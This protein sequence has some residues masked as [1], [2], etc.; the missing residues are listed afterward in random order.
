MQH[1]LGPLVM[2]R[3]VAETVTRKLILFIFIYRMNSCHTGRSMFWNDRVW[4]VL[5]DCGPQGSHRGAQPG[6]CSPVTAEKFRVMGLPCAQQDSQQQPCPLSMTASSSFFQQCQSQM[7]QT[8]PDVPWEA[9]TPGL[10]ARCGA[11]LL[12]ATWC[13]LHSRLYVPNSFIWKWTP[14]YDSSVITN[15]LVLLHS[16]KIN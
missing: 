10:A 6:L 9:R 14:K 11:S 3:G 12:V 13:L 7:P 8:L 2:L 5:K 15:L 4:Q 16:F 1:Q